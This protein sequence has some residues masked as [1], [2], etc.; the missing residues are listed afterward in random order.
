MLDGLDGNVLQWLRGFCFTVRLGGVTKAAR[1]MGVRQSTV[2][3]HIRNLE[4]SLN[5]RLFVRHHKE[6]EIT[7]AGRRLYDMAT[8]LLEHVRMVLD[9]ATLAPGE[10]KGVIRLATTHAMAQHFLGPTLRMFRAR[11]PDVRFSILG[12]GFGLITDAVTDGTADFGIVSQGDF[13]DPLAFRPLFGSRLVAVSPKGNPFRLPE[14]PGLEDLCLPPFIGFPPR[15]T[16]DATMRNLLQARNLEF[17]V[18]ISANTFY[19]LLEYVRAGLGITILDL[20]A[21]QDRAGDLDVLEIRDPLPERQYV[22]IWRRSVRF[23][24]HVSR[25]IDLLLDTPAP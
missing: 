24:E 17:N 20:F 3:H 4:K 25:Y 16:V 13:P 5:A 8:P 11:H 10:L 6:L 21:V 19:L 15:G 14:R 12:G 2:S 23:P 9:S 22:I 1:H 7:D 18:V